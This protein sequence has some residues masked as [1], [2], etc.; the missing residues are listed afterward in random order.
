V[1]EAGVGTAGGGRTA[2]L[3]SGGGSWFPEVICLGGGSYLRLGQ[4]R[5]GWLG[6]AV[7]V[8]IRLRMVFCIGSARLRWDGI[9][10]LV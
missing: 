7:T 2:G 3:D 5:V 1:G 9:I 8:S 6:L 10:M 4:A